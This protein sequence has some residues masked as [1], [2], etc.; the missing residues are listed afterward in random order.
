MFVFTYYYHLPSF[1][2]KEP[3]QITFSLY[4]D[5]VFIVAIF[6]NE[7]EGQKTFYRGHTFYYLRD[8]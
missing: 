4:V 8:V 7:S 3:S 5:V 1:W 6:Y 2:D